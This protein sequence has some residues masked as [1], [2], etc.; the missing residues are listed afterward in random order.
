MYYC[1]TLRAE[2]QYTRIKSSPIPHP[3]RLSTRISRFHR[4][5]DFIHQR[6][7]S[8]DSV[9]FH[10]S[11]FSTRISGFHRVSDFIHQRW[12]SSDSVGF[13]SFLSPLHPHQRI[14]SRERFHPPKV[15]FIRLRR[16]SLRPRRQPPLCKWAKICKQIGTRK[17]DGG[18]V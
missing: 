6:W 5:S 4:V 15:D 18:I 8:S 10:S 7:I 3:P 13:H 16:I 14:S 12:I 2:F 11:S 9:G 1:S 17:R